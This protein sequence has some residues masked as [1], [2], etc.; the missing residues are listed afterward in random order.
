MYER[1]Q[2]RQ[3]KKRIVHFGDRKHSRLRSGKCKS[4]GI[5][6]SREI[7]K[8]FCSWEFRFQREEWWGEIG[9]AVGPDGKDDY[10]NS[11]DSILE[12]VES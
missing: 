5:K 1:H 7:G 2:G 12:T 4:P 9:G 11:L 6:T 10:A 3:R 8:R